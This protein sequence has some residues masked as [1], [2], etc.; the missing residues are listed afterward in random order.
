MFNKENLKIAYKL[1]N[2]FLFALIIF[3]FLVMLAEGILPGIISRYVP[4]Y[5][6]ALAILADIFLVSLIK[7][8]AAIQE[9]KILNKKTINIFLIASGLLLLNSVL[10]FNIVLVFVI[11]IL[12][13]ASIYLIY[14]ILEKEI[15]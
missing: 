11:A 8:K 5:F 10:K 6:F 1:L 14:N 9:S 4:I 12:A 3:F 15:D 7:K 13:T 2:D